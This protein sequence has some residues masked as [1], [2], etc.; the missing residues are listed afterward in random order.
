[1]LSLRANQDVVRRSN[2]L[3]TIFYHE[4]NLVIAECRPRIKVCLARWLFAVDFRTKSDKAA[5]EGTRTSHKCN[6][7]L[8][9]ITANYVQQMALE[10]PWN[11]TMI[12]EQAGRSP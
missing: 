12:E 9:S 11:C 8:D 7:V 10:G 6:F 4:N 5:S 3:R 2:Q 1:M